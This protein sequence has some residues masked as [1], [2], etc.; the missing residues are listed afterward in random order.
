MTTLSEQL[1]AFARAVAESVGETMVTTGSLFDLNTLDKSSLVAAI[2]E[3]LA[4]VVA[5]QPGGGVVIDDVASGETTVWSSSRVVEYVADRLAV[6]IE[7]LPAALRIDD[8][9][10]AADTT[11]SSARIAQEIAAA[12]AAGGGAGTPG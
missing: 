2:N 11:W 10:V 5:G 6:Y 1:D 12:V 4:G 7:S 3:V 8:T 9:V